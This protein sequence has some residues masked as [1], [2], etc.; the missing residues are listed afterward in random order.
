MQVGAT[1]KDHWWVSL[2]FDFLQDRFSSTDLH[3]RT[4]FGS[5]IYWQFDVQ[6]PVS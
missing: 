3:R 1:L 6:N 4:V 5:C 2:Q